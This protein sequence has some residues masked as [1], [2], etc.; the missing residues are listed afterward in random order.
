MSYAVIRTGGKQ[1]RVSPG[2]RL[3]VEKLVGDPGQQVEFLEV[4]L[5]GDADRIEIGAPLVDGAAVRAVILQQDRGP[6]IL[7]YKKKRRK[8]YRRRM[9]HRQYETTVQITSI[10]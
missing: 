10:D 3:T 4:L 5:R 6:H 9:G 8:N 1:Y 7:V 2:A